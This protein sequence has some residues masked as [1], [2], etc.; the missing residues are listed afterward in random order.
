MIFIVFI[1]TFL[2]GSVGSS[3]IKFTDSQF[4]PVILIFFRAVL[5]SAI[6]GAFVYL[7]KSKFKIEKEKR[8]LF[9]SCLLFTLNWL[10]FA[11]GIQNTSVI[12]GQIIY[13]PTSLVVAAFG[14][15]FLSEKLS[16][17]QTIALVL[18][19][20]GMAILIHGS[21]S[22]SDVH[23]FGKPIGNLIVGLGMISWALCIVASR[24]ISSVYSPQSITLS[25]FLTATV[26]SLTLLLIPVARQ[27]WRIENVNA[28]G[29]VGLFSIVIFSSILF[30]G[31]SQWLIKYTSAFTASLVLYPMTLIAGTLGI[32][33]FHEKLTPNLVVGGVLVLVGVYVAT[34]LS[35]TRRLIKR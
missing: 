27:N 18:T 26:I 20:C 19:L 29:Y 15:I 2:S 3:L 34:A 25:N 21:I 4:P 33:F 6:F 16:K 1:L 30:F 13:L 12:M 7:T 5:S 11:I 31:L 14:Y 8:L 28:N 22:S 9:A 23:S 24:K 32:I 10:L 35:H 17:E